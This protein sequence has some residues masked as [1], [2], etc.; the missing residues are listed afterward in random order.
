MTEFDGGNDSM[1]NP[2]DEGTQSFQWPAQTYTVDCPYCGRTET[3]DYE[4]SAY[5][6]V[7][8]HIRVEHSD[9]LPPMGATDD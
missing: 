2:N 7:V 5:A 4:V 1:D 3:L 9:E 6:W 8:G